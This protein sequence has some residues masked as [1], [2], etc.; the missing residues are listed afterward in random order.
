M[1]MSPEQAAISLREIEE[2]QARS[3]ELR[4]YRKGS[5]HLILWGVLWM[6]AYAATGLQPRYAAP[7]WGAAVLTGIVGDTLIGW[8]PA[9]LVRSWRYYATVAT[10]ALFVTGTYL[11]F[12]PLRPIQ[13]GAF[14]PLVVAGV[15]AVLGIWLLPRFLWLGALL[16]VLTLGGFYFLQPWFG[17]WMAGAGGGCL[18]LGGWWLRSA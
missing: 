16:F 8:R 14:P 13:Y 17:F 4:G 1:S 11:V 9:E 15:Y 3:R 5:P 10:L 6:I 18:I 7:I 12:A 2:A